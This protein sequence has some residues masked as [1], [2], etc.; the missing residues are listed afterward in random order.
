MLNCVSSNFYKT[1]VSFDV[2]ALSFFAVDQFLRITFCCVTVTAWT[3]RALAS[4]RQLRAKSP[5]M[6]SL[7]HWRPS[8]VRNTALARLPSIAV[9]NALDQSSRTRLMTPELRLCFPRVQ[10]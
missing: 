2:S 7:T 6:R 5:G 8:D 10:R 9:E 1:L 4:R 3:S